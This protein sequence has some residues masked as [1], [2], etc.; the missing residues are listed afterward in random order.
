MRGVRATYQVKFP[1]R[2]TSPLSCWVAS[3][4]E[5]IRLRK[6]L[7][8]GWTGVGDRKHLR[9]LQPLVL[10]RAKKQWLLTKFVLAPQLTN[11]FDD[12]GMHGASEIGL[13]LAFLILVASMASKVAHSADI[14]C[15]R[16]IFALGDPVQF[17][18]GPATKG[19]DYA[20]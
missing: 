3:Y 6:V 13:G 20:F 16:S 11:L 14:K 17:E 18:L 10:G 15:C 9:Y 8:L 4:G 19:V 12:L 2:T 1:C 5:A 7:L